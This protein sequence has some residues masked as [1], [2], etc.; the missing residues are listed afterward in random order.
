MNERYNDVLT[1]RLEAY[2]SCCY[3]ELN[4]IGADYTKNLQWY[5]VNTTV[6]M[7]LK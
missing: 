1:A 5:F 3:L 4:R 2:G 7:F 6:I